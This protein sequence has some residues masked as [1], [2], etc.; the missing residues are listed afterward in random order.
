MAS[1]QATRQL[2]SFFIKGSV[3]LFA[4]TIMLVG[5]HRCLST[6]QIASLHG[7]E[8][9]ASVE[10][11]R[12][13]TLAS[14]NPSTPPPCSPGFSTIVPCDEPECREAFFHCHGGSHPPRPLPL[15][16]RSQKD[17]SPLLLILQ[18]TQATDTL[19]RHG[20]PGVLK[21]KLSLFLFL[22]FIYF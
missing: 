12:T 1:L 8:V 15:F 21:H 10:L 14:C 9:G 4:F 17:T 5:Q 18:I 16:P 6:A 13:W 20:V 2:L 3:G 19:N 7:E 11:T 22:M